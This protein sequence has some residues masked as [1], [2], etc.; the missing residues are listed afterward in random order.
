V[1]SLAVNVAKLIGKSRSSLGDTMF[2]NVS[3]CFTVAY[4][5]SLH[6]LGTSVILASLFLPATF[7]FFLISVRTLFKKS[8]IAC[9]LC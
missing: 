2:R 7:F 3:V 9:S 5:W 4:A 8:Q 1:L 6:C